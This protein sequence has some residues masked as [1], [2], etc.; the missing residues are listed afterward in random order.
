MGIYDIKKIETLGSFHTSQLKFSSGFLISRGPIFSFGLTKPKKVE[1][2][3]RRVLL[4]YGN[5]GKISVVLKEGPGEGGVIEKELEFKPSFDAYLKAMETVQS[6]RD[7]RKVAKNKTK[8]SGEDNGLGFLEKSEKKTRFQE[9]NVGGS[10][11]NELGFEVSGD[12]DNVRRLELVSLEQRNESG[13]SKG[14]AR[15]MGL[16]NKSSVGNVGG[17]RRND[18]VLEGSRVDV[19]RMKSGMLKQENKSGIV[20][21]EARKMEFKEKSNKGDATHLVRNEL[22]F[23]SSVDDVKVERKLG[24]VTRNGRWTNN[25][26]GG[27]R[28]TQLYDKFKGERYR[29]SSSYQTSKRDHFEGGNIYAH[30]A[31]QHVR[32]GRF[33]KPG[34]EDSGESGEPD[35]AAFRSLEE[36]NDIDDKPRVSRVDME[37]RIQRLAKR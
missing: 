20:K 8:K 7:K 6:V 15:K 27:V 26:S 18:L 13:I 12:G 32:R 5:C 3:S 4:G 28:E 21:G 35:R 24:V 16:K 31:Q 14:A 29:E 11:R 1:Q 19:E 23:R 33:G 22:K 30:S 34:Y 17:L 37:E 10:G 2:K 9:S 25:Q 36:Y